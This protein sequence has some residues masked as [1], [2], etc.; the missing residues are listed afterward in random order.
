MDSPIENIKESYEVLIV[1][2]G[3]VGAGIIRDL[4][5][6]DTS[7]AYPLFLPPSP[8]PLKS[9]SQRPHSTLIAMSLWFSLI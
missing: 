4:A 9:V 2:G 5:M 3:I 8:I 6:H 7:F 1:G